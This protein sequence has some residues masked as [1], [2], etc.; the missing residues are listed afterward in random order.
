LE[1]ASKSPAAKTELAKIDL[2]TLE[3]PLRWIVVTPSGLSQG[4]A[5]GP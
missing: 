4:S 5:R 3:S 1:A 2:I